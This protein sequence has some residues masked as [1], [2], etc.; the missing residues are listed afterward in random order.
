[1][2]VDSMGFEMTVGS[3]E[4]SLVETLVGTNLL[5]VGLEEMLGLIDLEVMR[6]GVLHVSYGHLLSRSRGRKK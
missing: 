5:L 1:M 4:Q 2:Y 6:D 3:Y